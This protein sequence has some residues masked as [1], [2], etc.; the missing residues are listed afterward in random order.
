MP[1][2]AHSD[3][4]AVVVTYHPSPDVVHNLRAVVAEC[5]DVIVVDNGSGDDVCARLSR[6]PGVQLLGLGENL[7]IATA[8][9]R[10]MR[11]A[12]EQGRK[13]V[14]TFDQDSTPEPGMVAAMLETANRSDREVIVGPRIREA[15]LEGESCWLRAHESCPLCFERVPCGERD[16]E[17]VSIIITSGALT[18][19]R[20][21]RELGGYDEQLFIDFVDTD[22]CL[23][24]TARGGRIAVCADAD[25]RHH[26][27]ARERRKAFGLRFNPTHHPAIRHY[28]IARNRIL[29]MQRH[30]NGAGHW[31]MFECASTLMWVARVLLFEQ[32][33]GRK[34]AAMCVGTWHG[35]I[36]CFGPC[37]A[38][39]A[40]WL[41]S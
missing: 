1:A 39:L 36:E 13:W 23:R 7:G 19:V 34:L 18:S 25:L 33:R 20:N 9:N 22:F 12:E 31:F 3:L 35:I 37:E 15:A 29:M 21:W 4:V 40:K 6:L 11:R 30:A 26:L 24:H 41:K 27:G 28:Y 38:R 32:S 8:L 17:R 14:V 16:L 5:G 2:E 10:G